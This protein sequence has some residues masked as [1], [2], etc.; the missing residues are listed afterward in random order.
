MNRSLISPKNL[1]LCLFIAISAISHITLLL[2]TDEDIN[3]VIYVI[4]NSVLISVALLITAKRN[5]V[6][7]DNNFFAALSFST[8]T[9]I[10]ISGS[11][12]GAIQFVV[13][14]YLNN[15]E[16]FC[17]ISGL[18][19]TMM[20]VSALL[21]RI[22]KNPVNENPN[23]DL[24][25]LDVAQKLWPELEV[26]ELD[27]VQ[28]T[29]VHFGMREVLKKATAEQK[30]H[31]DLTMNFYKI[32]DGLRPS[33][34]VSEYKKYLETVGQRVVSEIYSK[35]LNEKFAQ[36]RPPGVLFTSFADGQLPMLN[37]VFYCKASGIIMIFGV[38]MNQGVLNR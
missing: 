34:I 21:I 20:I 6:N 27:Q 2:T 10:G 37:G 24:I 4:A 32:R 8:I 22:K 3:K 26:L 7:P 13:F 15:F 9:A 28:V 31:P 36:H 29:K 1:L 38:V 14:G 19:I 30:N 35:R 33:V 16:K 23:L 11:S 25:F 12:F 17:V 5:W 18:S